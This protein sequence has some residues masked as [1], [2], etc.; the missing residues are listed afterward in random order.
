MVS[1][2]VVSQI[3]VYWNRRVSEGHAAQGVE[4]CNGLA[5]A[6]AAGSAACIVY[7]IE[8]LL[9]ATAVH[10]FKTYDIILTEITT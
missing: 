9:I 10:I 8:A 7:A 3:F 2:F 5:Y 4:I 6:Y 1:R